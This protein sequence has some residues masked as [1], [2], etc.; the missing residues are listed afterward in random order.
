[1]VSVF[2]R[3]P[4]RAGDW[5]QEQLPDDRQIALVFNS[6]GLARLRAEIPRFD[7]GDTTVDFEKEILVTAFMGSM[8]TGGYDIEV[9]GVAYLP[10]DRGDMARATIRLAA[11]SPAPDAFVTQAF[12]FPSHAVAVPID[13]WP[14]EAL[15]LISRGEILL[16]AVDQDARNWGPVAVYAE[17]EPDA[18]VDPEESRDEESGPAK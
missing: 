2:D 12:T 15:E 17:A 9:T 6:G 1:M 16:E 18:A 10:P 14:D 7:L 5:R 3:E 8:P 13:A 4:S 11:S